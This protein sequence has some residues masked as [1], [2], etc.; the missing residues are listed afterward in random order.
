[1]GTL[2][3]S[4]RAPIGYLAISEVPVAVNQ[5]FISIPPGPVLPNLYLLYWCQVYEED[6]INYANG[7]TF[8]ADY[9]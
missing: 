2:L 7:S 5:G 8:L 1:M 4:S 3:L 6:I 9:A